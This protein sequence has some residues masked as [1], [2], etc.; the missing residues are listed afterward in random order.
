MSLYNDV[1][2]LSCGDNVLFCGLVHEVFH[3]DHLHHFTD[4]TRT[5]TLFVTTLIIYQNDEKFKARSKFDGL[6]L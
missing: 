1:K 4:I 5:R 6:H 3:F 2:V